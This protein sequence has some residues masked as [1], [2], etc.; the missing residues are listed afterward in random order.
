LVF[1]LGYQKVKDFD[2]INEFKG[3]SDADNGLSF[4][5]DSTQQ[6]YEFFGKDVT[7]GELITDEGSMNQFNASGAMDI[8]PNVSFGVALNYWSGKSDYNLNFTQTDTENNFPTF[9][10]DFYQYKEN[11]II[12]T[13]YSGFNVVL[14]AMYRLKRLARIGISYSSPVTFNVNEKFSNPASRNSPILHL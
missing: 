13:E 1:A 9:P 12:N 4:I 7:R 3:F 5:V 11:R 6:V 14:A 10:A 2:Y 8:S